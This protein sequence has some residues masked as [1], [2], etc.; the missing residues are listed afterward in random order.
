[1]FA[2]EWEKQMREEPAA[3]PS[4]SCRNQSPNLKTGNV[5]WLTLVGLGCLADVDGQLTAEGVDAHHPGVSSRAGERRQLVV[6][7]RNA[8]E[9]LSEV[10]GT[11]QDDLLQG[12]G[13]HKSWSPVPNV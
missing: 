3:A 7:A 12:G 8:V 9:R 5:L 2:A 1:M 10:S 13:R 11:L 6:A 4:A